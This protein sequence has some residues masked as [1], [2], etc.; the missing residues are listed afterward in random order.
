MSHDLI[1]RTLILEGMFRGKKEGFFD[2]E[3]DGIERQMK[4]GWVGLNDPFIATK[5]WRGFPTFAEAW[6]GPRVLTSWDAQIHLI[7]NFVFVKA[8]SHTPTDQQEIGPARGG[9]VDKGGMIPSVWL[10]NL[11]TPRHRPEIV[12]YTLSAINTHGMPGVS[13]NRNYK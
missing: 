2:S 11:Q 7:I 3:V 13:S 9:A 8:F 6:R 5:F 1:K 12:W 4:D 10:H